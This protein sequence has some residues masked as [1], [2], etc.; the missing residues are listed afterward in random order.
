VSRF[1]RESALTI[2][3]I[4]PVG[5]WAAHADHLDGLVVDEIPSDRGV[6]HIGLSVHDAGDRARERGGDLHHIEG[7]N[8]ACNCR[9][10]G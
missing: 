2:G 6:G 1:D 3:L 8:L 9:G 7:I 5:R 10:Q 4:D